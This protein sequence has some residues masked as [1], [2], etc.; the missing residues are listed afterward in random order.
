MPHGPHRTRN[1]IASRRSTLPAA[2]GSL[3]CLDG[4][5]AEPDA[6]G[7]RSVRNDAAAASGTPDPD[8]AS[9][10]DDATTAV[11]AVAALGDL[12]VTKTADAGA[13]VL[14]GQ[15]VAFTL[16][17]ANESERTHGVVAIDQPS[18]AVTVN[19][20]QPE[21]GSC[22]GLTCR[23]GDMPPGDVVLVQDRRQAI[24]EGRQGRVVHDHRDQHRD[25]R[26]E[27]GARMRR[28]R[29][30][31]RV[32][33]RQGCEVRQG[34]AC[35]TSPMLAAGEKV[36]FRVKMRVSGN[37][38]AERFVN[39]ATVTSANAAADGEL[40]P[41]FERSYAARVVTPTPACTAPNP[42]RVSISNRTRT[43]R[44]HRGGQL[45]RRFPA[46]VGSPA[47]HA[48]V[49]EALPG[50]V[51][52]L[53]QFGDGLLVGADRLFEPVAE[54]RADHAHAFDDQ[55]RTRR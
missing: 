21:R 16:R 34:R 26:R 1:R 48:T 52:R 27:R 22:A 47:A 19:S 9:K 49:S 17:V 4:I 36:R 11:D 24:G 25:H 40:A 30:E 7:D 5:V 54:R 8:P 32:R 53:G 15:P 37:T 23:L 6:V 28:P 42:W 20:V 55:T 10:G 13:R 45:A 3:T 43:V 46:V 39:R 18:A 38:R 51:A 12:S 31:R 44:V 41:G 2:A 50:S 35:W 14:L 29:G 33:D